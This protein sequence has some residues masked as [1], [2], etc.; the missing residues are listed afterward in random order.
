MDVL[1]DTAFGR[2][3]VACGPFEAAPV[4]AVGVSGGAD[5]LALALLAHAWASARGGRVAAFTV[6]H[7]LRPEAAVEAQR[8]GQW[9]A[10]RGI[11]HHILPVTAPLAAGS[12]QAAARQ[13]R[14]DLLLR[15]CRERSIMHLLIAHQAEDQAETLAMRRSR[16]P[17]AS[18]MAAI[19]PPPLPGPRWPRLLRPLL[20]V[21]RETLRDYL[22][23]EGQPWID[24]PS[25]ENPAFER[26]RVR[27]ALAADQ[28]KRLKY[29]QEA[30]EAGDRRQALAAALARAAAP[31]VTFHPTGFALVDGPGM[32]ALS[33]ELGAALWWRLLTTVGGRANAPRS[34][35]LQPFLDRLAAVPAV[36][37][38]G[39]RVIRRRDGWLV[40][41]DPAS[42]RDVGVLPGTP[43]D[44]RFVLSGP[45]HRPIRHPV[46]RLT[47]ADW[48]ELRKSK[49]AEGLSVLPHVVRLGLPVWLDEDGAP[50]PFAWCGADAPTLCFAPVTPFVY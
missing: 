31:L 28:A 45:A 3:L 22:R 2:L 12:V 49:S 4:L 44:G 40:C 11:V 21:A 42:V 50:Q 43:W 24:D 10:A 6:D 16:A 9:L 13:A 41:R 17:D 15:A 48:R 33:P 19:S 23:R 39:C 20:P 18:A 46:R 7:G 25:N 38:G 14:Y 1:G 27:R 29:F 34:R 26:V 32:A 5:S 35:H 30:G 37:L 47:E 36:T 8:V